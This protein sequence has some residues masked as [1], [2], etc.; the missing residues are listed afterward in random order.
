MIMMD[1]LWSLLGP[2]NSSQ[3]RPPGSRVFVEYS[4]GK[5][6]INTKFPARSHGS[7]IAIISSPWI[8]PKN[9]NGR[10]VLYAGLDKLVSV[11]SNFTRQESLVFTDQLR[12][13][14]GG[15]SYIEKL[16]SRKP[17][18][19]RLSRPWGGG[20]EARRFRERR[21]IYTFLF[22][23]P[24]PFPWILHCLTP[25]LTSLCLHLVSPC[26][27]FAPLLPVPDL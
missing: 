12:E 1:K 18:F 6:F 16:P 25:F 19:P 24:P 14:G 17:F 11:W 22:V 10:N 20:V 23:G 3:V 27:T 21:R 26:M 7:L 13:G 8:R 4:R 15:G 9:Q 2:V 5:L